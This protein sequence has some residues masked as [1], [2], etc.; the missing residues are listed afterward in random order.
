MESNL[1]LSRHNGDLLAN[2]ASY[3]R[4]VGRLLYLTITRPDISYSVQILSQV[5]VTP[6]Q[7]HIDAATR[8][9]KY[10]KH[11]PSQG[12]FYS[13]TSAS[14]LNAFCDFDWAG[15]PDT[16]RSI[17]GYCVFLGDFLISWKSNK[18]HTVSHSSAEAEYRSMVAITCE[19]TLLLY[20]LKDF[21]IYH[22]KPALLF[23]D[24]QAALH[25]AAN[26]VFHERTKH[27]ELD[28]H[29]VHDKLQ[30]NV[31]W[32]LHVKSLH[33]LADLFTKALGS[34]FSSFVIQEEHH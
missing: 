4:L 12:L 21:T 3:R 14:H 20:L 33:Q 17:T 24:S 32:T 15:C 9:L 6:Q 5:M 8:V 7:P 18:Q 10:L 22:P 28:C 11:S 34:N 25:I 1:K 23:C 30:E 31:I 19:I 26:P 27:I 2:P 13:S 29:L 16:R